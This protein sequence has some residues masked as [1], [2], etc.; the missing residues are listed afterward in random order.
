[1]HFLKDRGFQHATASEITPREA[2]EGRRAMLKLMAGGA[3]GA[4][5]AGWAGRD[6]LAQ[7]AA[8]SLTSRPVTLTATITGAQSAVPT[9]TG[10]VE[11]YD[12]ATLLGSAALSPQGT[13]TLVTTRISRTGPHSLTARYTG[14]FNY[15]A[16]TSGALSHE[17]RFDPAL[18]V[19]ILDLILQ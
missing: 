8:Q 4:A 12:G 11:F 16:S 19:P 6:A 14:D 3:A 18:L 10:N 1:M 5:L 7:S 17:T 15:Q 13:A 2:Y 9:P